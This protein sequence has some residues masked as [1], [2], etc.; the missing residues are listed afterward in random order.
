M[1]PPKY[2]LGEAASAN[3]HLTSS[4]DYSSSSINDNNNNSSNS[5][6]ER[7]RSHP[8]GPPD[9]RIGSFVGASSIIKGPSNPQDEDDGLRVVR[10]HA[11]EKKASKEAF[12]LGGKERVDGEGCE[13]SA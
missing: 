8:E 5:I 11:A 7:P 4:V 6:I 3:L 13:R 2:R 10:A 12:D 1:G 9:D